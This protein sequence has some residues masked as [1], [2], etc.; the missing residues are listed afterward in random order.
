MVL[1]DELTG[2]IPPVLL[3]TYGLPFDIEVRISV[4]VFLATVDTW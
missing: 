3:H 1:A 4:L 2:D